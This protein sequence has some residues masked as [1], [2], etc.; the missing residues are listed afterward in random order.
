VFTETGDDVL[1]RVLVEEW[2][3]EC[4]GY[5]HELPGLYSGAASLDL[6]LDKLP[7][8]VESHFAW[9]ASHGFSTANDSPIELEITESLPAIDGRYGPLF[10]LDLEAVTSER[11]EVAIAVAALARRDL[12]DLYRSV[13]DVRRSVTS[14]N[15]A[16]TMRQHLQHTASTEVFYVDRLDGESGIV[17]PD[18]PVK[19]LQTSGRH[20][21][22]L[23]RGW[24]AAS[25]S[26][27]VDRGGEEWTAGKVL[28][29]MTGHLRE[30]LPWVQALAYGT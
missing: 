4:G 19:A 16:W 18:D 25:R 11:L 12:V 23:L 2:S 6:L 17:L 8:A 22:A 20:A 1:L 28:R 9:L 24:D 27:L 29:R 13:S 7:A 21:D 10:Q 5:V 3:A 14:S 26:I 15:D 30:H